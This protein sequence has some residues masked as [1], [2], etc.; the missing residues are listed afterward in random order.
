MER[1]GVGFETSEYVQKR[2]ELG[3]AQQKL[4]AHCKATGL[5]RQYARKKAYGVTAQP[6]ALWSEAASE[7]VRT[8][9]GR[10]NI[11]IDKFVPCLLEKETGELVETNVFKMKSR[12]KLKE[13]NSKTGWDINWSKI[14]DD[15]EIYALCVKGSDTIEGLIALKEDK[16]AKA[17]YL[18]YLK[19][20]PHNDKRT[21]GLKKYEGIGG[22]LIAIAGEVS[23]KKGYDGCVYGFAE[24]LQL[25]EHYCK[26]YGAEYVGILHP[27]QFVF[28]SKVM[29]SIMNTY[30]YEW[31]NNGKNID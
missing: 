15:K 31:R 8:T 14:E 11:E 25:L 30:T 20:A 16:D 12:S 3:A 2:L 4:V 27:N 7:V 18:H 1:V 19:A 9:E 23:Y 6:R 29:K 10:V 21:N 22:H 13:Y 17:V 24:N 5:T 26:E 28:S